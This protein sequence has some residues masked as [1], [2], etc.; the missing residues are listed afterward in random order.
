[1][2]AR[3][4][5]STVDN[6]NEVGRVSFYL[7]VL[8]NANYDG[9]VDNTLT[10][11]V[12]ALRIAVNGLSIANEWT[13]TVTAI[14]YEVP[15]EVPN[16][17]FAQRELKALFTYTALD[18]DGNA[19]T[20]SFEIPAFDAGQFAQANTDLIDLTGVVIAPLIASIEANA[21]SEWGTA[22]TITQGRIVG[23]TS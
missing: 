23:R 18:S 14:K 4:T 15:R 19:Q 6:S 20:R 16:N 22:I 1:M 12:G 2:T 13:Q 9:V 3:V 8:S 10:G 21:V 17:G 11:N 5:L 7:P